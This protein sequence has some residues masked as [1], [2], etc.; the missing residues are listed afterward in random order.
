MNTIFVHWKTSLA[1][2]LSAVTVIVGVLMAQGIT[3]GGAGKGTVVQ[4][5]GALAAGLT[6]LL[7]KDSTNPPQ[8]TK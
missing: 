2:L 1:G 6:G 8:E 7:A 5:I 3:G 4:L